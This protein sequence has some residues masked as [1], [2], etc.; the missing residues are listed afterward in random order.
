MVKRG[1]IIVTIASPFQGPIVQVASLIL[2]ASSLN[3]VIARDSSGL[4][5][6]LVVSEDYVRHIG[7]VDA[8]LKRVD[9]QVLTSI[10]SFA[11]FPGS[12]GLSVTTPSGSDIFYVDTAA[13]ATAAKRAFDE[14]YTFDFTAC[15]QCTFTIKFPEMYSASEFFTTLVFVASCWQLFK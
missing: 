13:C 3:L 5:H 14:E 7:N 1:Q 8:K 12:N 11:V 10:T 15:A 2:S 6:L 4:L 9:S